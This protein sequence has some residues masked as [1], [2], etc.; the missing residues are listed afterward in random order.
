MAVLPESMKKLDTSNVTGSLIQIENYIGYICE[1]IEFAM[2]NMTR[3]VGDAAGVSAVDVQQDISDLK[4]S[5]SK[6]NNTV[7]KM[8]G[9]NTG[10]NNRIDDVLE[11]IKTFQGTVT[12]LTERVATLE[13]G[14]GG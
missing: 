12:D 11:S 2:S 3:A 14:N 9:E 4:S 7:N 10:T 6:L 8:V 1:R 13:A 5:L